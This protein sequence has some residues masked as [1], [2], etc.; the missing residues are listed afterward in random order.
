[1]TY[2]DEQCLSAQRHSS[3]VGAVLCSYMNLLDISESEK[4]ENVSDIQ[5]PKMV[6]VGP[7]VNM[8]NL[9]D[10]SLWVNHPIPKQV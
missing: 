3:D 10:H 9:V 4:C 8:K 5:F 2:S 6:A 1:M 7:F